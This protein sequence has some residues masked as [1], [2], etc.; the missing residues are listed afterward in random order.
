MES[1]VIV[2]K[3]PDT[4]DVITLFESKKDGKTYG[5]IR[6]DSTNFVSNNGITNVVKRVAFETLTPETLPAMTPLLKADAPY[7]IKGKILVKETLEPQYE[8]QVPKLNPSTE[9]YVTVKGHQVYRT[10]SFTSD[11]NADDILINENTIDKFL[12][13]E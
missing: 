7:P 11:M 8:G 10:T 2:R 5:R 12:G 4:G 6:L 9:Q 1:N 3:H 13:D